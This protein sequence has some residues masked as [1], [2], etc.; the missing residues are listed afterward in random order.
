MLSEKLMKALE[1]MQNSIVLVPKGKFI[2]TDNPGMDG[3]MGNCLS[4]CNRSCTTCMEP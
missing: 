4:E 3:C 1:S 2:S